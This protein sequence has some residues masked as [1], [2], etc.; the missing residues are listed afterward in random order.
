MTKLSKMI[1][2]PRSSLGGQID[3][4][5]EEDKETKVKTKEDTDR[6]KSAVNTRGVIPEDNTTRV[7]KQ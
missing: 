2:K 5:I 4:V 1:K 6:N 7:Y 3:E